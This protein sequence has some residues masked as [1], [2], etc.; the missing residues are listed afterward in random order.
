M[1]ENKKSTEKKKTEAKDDRSR[2]FF[3]GIK[4]RITRK[5]PVRRPKESGSNFVVL[6][7]R[8]LKIERSEFEESGSLADRMSMFGDLSCFCVLSFL[9]ILLLEKTK[10]KLKREL[11]SASF[12]ILLFLIYLV[13]LLGL[14]FNR[15]L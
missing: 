9:L 7:L 1:R 4:Q 13:F 2:V 6:G 10:S 8:T 12:Y 5:T 15:W 14:P 3:S 11:I